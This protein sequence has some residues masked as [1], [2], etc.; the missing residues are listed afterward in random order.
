MVDFND[1]IVQCFDE[2]NEF[3]DCFNGV[4]RIRLNSSEVTA[5]NVQDSLNNVPSIV[6]GPNVYRVTAPL[7]NSQGITEIYI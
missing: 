2:N 7:S 3:Q 1:Y 5:E 4:F 6:F